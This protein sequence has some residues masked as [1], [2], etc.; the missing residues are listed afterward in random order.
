MDCSICLGDLG[1]DYVES[2]CHHVFHGEC[3]EGWLEVGSTCPLCRTQLVE[4][5][6]ED[7]DIVEEFRERGWGWLVAM[8]CLATGCLTTFLMFYF[9]M[10]QEEDVHVRHPTSLTLY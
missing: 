5:R 6:I 9:S 8:L 4:E 2:P 3:L 7:D 1:D 10:P